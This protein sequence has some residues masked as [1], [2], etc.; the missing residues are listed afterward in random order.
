MFGPCP[1]V[2]FMQESA[3]APPGTASVEEMEANSSTVRMVSFIAEQL[4]VVVKRM[5]GLSEKS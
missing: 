3:G 1:G 4:I 5:A 2:R